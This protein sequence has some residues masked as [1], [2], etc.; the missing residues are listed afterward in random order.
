MIDRGH[1]SVSIF[2]IYTGS[3]IIDDT[4]KLLGD[5]F[6]GQNIHIYNGKFLG[7]ILVVNIW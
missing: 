6:L 5:H 3:Y 1:C 7:P 2:I 4:L